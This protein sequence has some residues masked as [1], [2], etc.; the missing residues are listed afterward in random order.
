MAGLFA[1]KGLLCS[2]AGIR[3]GVQEKRSRPQDAGSA[4]VGAELAT[5]G[6]I[7]VK[8]ALDGLQSLLDELGHLQRVGGT[9]Q[10][11]L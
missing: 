7:H 2:H 5:T 8:S 3:C 6:G 1:S 4:V 10:G 9:A 11:D